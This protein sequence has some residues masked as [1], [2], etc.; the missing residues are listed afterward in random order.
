MTK[1]TA[2]M[3]PIGTVVVDGTK[4][5]RIIAILDN[6]AVMRPEAAGANDRQDFFM[7]IDD[8]HNKMAAVDFEL[9]L[10]ALKSL[11]GSTALPNNRPGFLDLDDAEQRKVLYNIAAM[12]VLQT[13]HKTLG[14]KITEAWINDNHAV[15]EGKS[16]AKFRELAGIGRRRSKEVESFELPA[17]KKLARMYKDSQA[18]FFEPASLATQHSK[19]GRKP[20]EYPDWVMG[21][22]EKSA[23]EYLDGREKSVKAG[24]LRLLGTLQEENAR[25]SGTVPGHEDVSVSETKYRKIVASMPTAA[26][27]ATRKGRDEMIRSMRAGIGEMI[28]RMVGEVV[29]F[30][31]CEM[32][33][34]V[35]LE[36][37]G[38]HRVVGER[39]MK[40]LRKE[41]END[42]IG[43]VWILV[44]Y[45]VAS[46]APLA[47]HIARSQNADDT[48]ELIRRLVSDKTKLAREAGCQHPP[49]PAV[50]PFQIVM[51][52]GSGLWNGVVPT[53]ILKLGAMFRFGRTKTPTDKAFIE[54]FF[55]TLGDDV[56]RALHGHS[57]NGP[58]AVS[59]YDG[60]EMTVLTIA[61]L[62][63]YLWW[64]FCDCLPFKTTQRKG[65]WGIQRKQLFDRLCE[66]YGRLPALSRREVRRAVGLE[67]TRVVTKMGI[68]AFRMPFQGD[69]P[70]RRWVLDNIDAKVTVYVDPHSLEEVTVKTP[71]G[72]IFYF[73]SS[74]SQFKDFTLQEWVHFLEEWRA[75]DPVSK[76][77]AVEALHRFYQRIETENEK[78]LDFYG[79][80]HRTIKM[81]DAQRLCDDLAG[82][83]LSILPYD[84]GSDAASPMDIYQGAESGNGIF[85]PG[86]HVIEDAEIIEDSPAV[87]QPKSKPTKTFT[88][89]AKGK[90]VLK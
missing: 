28:A 39:T 78:L 25:R 75:S 19:A 22:I 85:V 5:S 18:D 32:S 81:G 2:P 51:D 65:G 87:P 4:R 37:T 24:F 6:M 35:F 40:Q 20:T 84:G 50:R 17:G 54:R 16:N 44:A 33:L 80:E 70:G 1:Y 49:P 30:D 21:L 56:F 68:E 29:Q 69:G 45:D 38:L 64:Y 36:K 77:I 12:F 27:M 13:Y 90:G 34:W 15:I 73:K 79:K 88:G 74:L 14:Q 61:Q 72:Q 60:Q 46:G 71:D 41:A 3:I 9:Q 42:A 66:D 23:K 47:F 48:L 63:K 83:D 62:E 82:N 57:G 59:S 53:A 67:L 55:E 43:K 8:I 76:S 26:V 86:S 52:T 58:G 31:E 11:H 89:A 10:P 7:S